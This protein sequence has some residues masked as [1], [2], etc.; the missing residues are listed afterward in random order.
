MTS[1]IC[2]QRPSRTRR[3]EVASADVVG[4]AAF[5]A[6]TIIEAASCALLQSVVVTDVPHG[7]MGNAASL[8]APLAAE[9]QSGTLGW[10]RHFSLILLMSANVV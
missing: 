9:P 4:E 8:V 10:F 3:R 2:E 5:S 1:T 6:S 7:R